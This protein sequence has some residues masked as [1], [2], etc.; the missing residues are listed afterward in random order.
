MTMVHFQWSAA[1]W[2]L[3]C[4]LLFLRWP[5]KGFS[6]VS[7][8]MVVDKENAFG[9]HWELFIYSN[10]VGWPLAAR[11]TQHTES[12]ACTYLI[13]FHFIVI[14]SSSCFV[15]CIHHTFILLFFK[16]ICTLLH[17]QMYHQTQTGAFMASI[18]IKNSS[19]FNITYITT[20]VPRSKKRH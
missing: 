20:D 6:N 2:K 14:F 17:V 3:W 4:V 18:V 16:H 15:A 10:L 13:L 11:I 5:F 12:S 8:I 9:G 7:F 1:H 19:R